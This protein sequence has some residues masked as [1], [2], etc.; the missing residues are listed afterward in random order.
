MTCS[1][2]TY[3]TTIPTPHPQL[4]FYSGLVCLPKAIFNELPW[5]SMSIQHGCEAGQQVLLCVL[6][7]HHKQQ[8]PAQFHPSD[9]ENITDS[10]RHKLG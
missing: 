5:A 2:L 3:C 8:L 10:N 6:F 7:Y 1:S 9:P 4:G